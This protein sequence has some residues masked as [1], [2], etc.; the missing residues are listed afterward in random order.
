[1]HRSLQESKTNKN[2]TRVEETG[3]KTVGALLLTVCG[4]VLSCE[5]RMDDD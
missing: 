5:F 2:L 4:R 1:M 3:R